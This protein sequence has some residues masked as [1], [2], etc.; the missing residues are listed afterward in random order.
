LLIVG[1][2][3]LPGLIENLPPDA[4]LA[5]GSYDP[6]LPF[7][8]SDLIWSAYTVIALLDKS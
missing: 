7:S 4:Q 8:L 6:S 3:G 1:R 5:T 2:D